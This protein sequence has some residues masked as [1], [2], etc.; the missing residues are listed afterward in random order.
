SFAMYPIVAQGMGATSVRVPLTGDMCHDLP[1]MSA[2]V[3]DRTRL[4]F[5][6]NPNNP[7]GT[8]IGAEAFDRFVESLPDRVVLAVDEAYFEFVRRPDFPD[9]LAWIRRRPGTIAL[10]TFSKI[11]GLA[12]L[13]IGYGIAD[14]ELAGYL[15][16]ARHPFNVS[17]LAEVA[18]LAALDDVEHAARARATNSEGIDYLRRELGALG[19]E[20]WPTDANFVLA[21]AGPETAERLLREGIIVRSLSGFG[22]PDHIRISIGLPEE[23]ERLVKT[24]RKM[25]EGSL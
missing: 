8:S 3:T 7:T 13:R 24:L 12:G 1:K 2:A 15:Q 5:V 4:I 14:P 22:M 6:C 11:F 9:S 16:Q 10:R 18:A 20:T 25:R 21:K 23:N 19:V 17:R